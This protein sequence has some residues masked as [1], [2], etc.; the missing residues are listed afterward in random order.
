MNGRTDHAGWFYDNVDRCGQYFCHTYPK[1]LSFLEARQLSVLL[2]ET[3]T[4]S[5]QVLNGSIVELYFKRVAS[6]VDDL[7]NGKCFFHHF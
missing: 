5:L 2:L 3:R 6:F 4:A 1:A 7:G